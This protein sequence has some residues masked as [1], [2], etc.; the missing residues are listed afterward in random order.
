MDNLKLLNYDSATILELFQNA[1]YAEYG[2]PMVIGSDNF[3]AS[4]I[5]TYC[6]AVLVN[7]M[8]A[9]SYQRFIDSATG[10]YLDAIAAVNGLTRPA[11]KPASA[12]FLVTRNAPY[13]SSATIPVGHITISDG[14]GR[15]FTNLDPVFYMAG[16]SAVGA[17]LFCTVSGAAMNGIPENAINHIVEDGGYITEAH[18]STPTS[19][20]RDVMTN[21]AEFRE[22]IKTQ[23]SAYIVGGTAPAYRARAID[24]DT[25]IIDAYVAQ[26][27]DAV[28]EKGKIKIYTLFDFD[29]V[30]MAMRVHI[31]ERVKNACT[32]ED[33]RPVGDFVVVDQAGQTTL[34]IG[35]GFK[36]KYPLKF[37]DVC[38]RHFNTVM[39]DYRKYL[40]NGFNR[41]FSEA[42][43]AKR[44][45]TPDANGV[46]ALAF[47][48]T[49][50]HAAWLLPTVGRVYMLDWVWRTSWQSRTVEEYITGGTFELVNTGE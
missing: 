2:A 50:T 23:R 40:H 48:Y 49:L 44:L 4:A 26:D 24:T 34:Y 42:E 37:K 21:D 14:N 17:L 5:M 36:C 27:G 39:T 7:A 12:L 30:V 41:A 9:A 45:I 33:F 25:R 6:L 31:N 29:E 1:Y 46:Y 35:S 38:V 18:N 13:T 11:A 43:L 22:Y 3:T 10:S 16:Q 32:A 47:D 8:N 28:F 19:G 20:G 15:E